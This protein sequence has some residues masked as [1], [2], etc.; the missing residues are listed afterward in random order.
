MNKLILI[1]NGFDLAHGLKTK[2][3]DFLVWYLNKSLSKLCNQSIFEDEL[4]T[5]KT[6]SPKLIQ[7]LESIGKFKDLLGRYNIN[8]KPKN[9]FIENII[10][11]AIQYNWVDIENQYYLSLIKIYKILES[12]N[13][14]NSEYVNNN[15]KDLNDSFDP[16]KNRLEDYLKTI[17]NKLSDGNPE[18]YGHVNRELNVDYGHVTNDENLF[19]NFN[20]TST[21]ELYRSIFFYDY[22]FQVNNIHGKLGDANNPIIFG[23]GDERDIYFERMERLNNNEFLKN[24]KTFS[25]LKTRNYQD[26][27]KFIESKPFDVHI[28]GHSCGLSDRILLKTIFEHPNCQD[29]KIFYYQ[30]S[31]DEN[32]FTEKTHEISRHF[33]DNAMMRKKVINYQ[34]CVPLVTYEPEEVDAFS[35]N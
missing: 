26:F 9:E 29:I 15:L 12:N 31:K 32:D 24:I 22:Q 14:E 23:Y 20:Y 5:L 10:E 1:G 16:I 4:I 28:M 7:K 27:L 2:Y 25:Y 17:V 30:K 13:I 33:S 3:S 6:T 19:L 21:I 11:H 34:D 8:Y 35:N 18:I